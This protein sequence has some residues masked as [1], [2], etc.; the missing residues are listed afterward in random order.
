MKITVEPMDDAGKAMDLLA[1]F[2]RKKAADAPIMKKAMS[3][4]VSLAYD[5]GK[6]CYGNANEY[7]IHA[8]G[9]VT[10][11]TGE[12]EK[13]VKDAAL[14][15]L[16]YE[17]QRLLLIPAEYPAKID[18]AEHNYAEAI[19]KGYRTAEK[20]KSDKRMLEAELNEAK[21]NASAYEK[22]QE[23]AMR[24]DGIRWYTRRVPGSESLLICGTAMVDGK[25]YLYSNTLREVPRDYSLSDRDFISV[26]E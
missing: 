13:R 7:E 22:I 2:V 4:Y 23:K 11:L 20:W 19:A 17:L 18:N 3:L 25:K 21:R 26:A 8:D 6:S 5:D 16:Q 9:T 24:G 10:D 12:Q 1:A 14:Q 15:K